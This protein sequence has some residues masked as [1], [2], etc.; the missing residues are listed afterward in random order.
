[1]E[2]GL[3]TIPF[4]KEA[5]QSNTAGTEH[6]VRGLMNLMW[7]NNGRIMGHI[8]DPVIAMWMCELAID[9]RESKR[10]NTAT[11]DWL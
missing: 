2:K 3:Y 11:W 5:S 9:A 1:M 6:L 10:L 7:D 4:G 8:A